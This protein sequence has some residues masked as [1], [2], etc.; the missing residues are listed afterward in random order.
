M[1]SRLDDRHRPH[2]IALY[3]NDLLIISPD[4]AKIEHIISGLEQRYGIK[5]L[6]PAKYILGIQI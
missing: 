6:G 3:V 5:R 2:Y 4:L 1:Y